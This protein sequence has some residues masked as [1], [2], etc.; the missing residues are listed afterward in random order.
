MHP[1]VAMPALQD[2]VVLSVAAHADGAGGQARARRA[3]RVVVLPLAPQARTRGSA[4]PAPD[5]PFAL[6]AAL[7]NSLQGRVE[8][9]GVV[10]YIAVITQQESSRVGGLPAGLAHGALQTPPALAENHFSDLN[11][12]A[13]RVVA[14]TAL[15]TGQQPA[16]RSLAEA[17]ADHAHVL[18]QGELV[19]AGE[20]HHRVVHGVLFLVLAGGQVGSGHPR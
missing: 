19:A 10:A 6:P 15:R 1:S 4:V 9:V 11:A 7:G 3:L 17:A 12:D 8:A 13:V 14:L 5:A 2:E 18:L 16:L 20:Q